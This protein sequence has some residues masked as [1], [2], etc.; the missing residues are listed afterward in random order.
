[1]PTLTNN[2]ER[3][4]VIE[5][6]QG[7]Y[8]CFPDVCVAPNGDL[9]AV[10]NE[11]D[12]HVSTRSRLL[13]KRSADKG[14]TWSDPAYL[15]SDVSHCPRLTLLSGG[16]LAMLDDAG[17]QV[18]WSMDSGLSWSQHGMVG[19]THGLLDRIIELDHET[20][21]TTGHSHRGTYPHPKTRQPTTE[22]M[23]YISENRG[24]K[25]RPYSVM[26][27]DKWLV[28]CEASMTMLPDGSLLALLRENSMVY[29]PMYKSISRDSG[30]TW[31]PPAPTPLIGHRPT[32]ALTKSGKLLIT[33]RDVGPS[34]G[35]AAWLGDANELDE[36]EVH[37]LTPD[38]DV[39]ALTA[40]GLLIKSASG[41]DSL[42]RYALR[43]MTDPETAKAELETEVRVDEA[44]D[45]A[46]G[47]RLGAW[48]RIF[49]DRIEVELPDTKDEDQPE[50]VRI[51]PVRFNT[52]RVNYEKGRCT[53]TVNGE[54][55]ITVDADPM[56]ADTRA[57]LFGTI[58]PKKKNAGQSLWKNVRLSIDE[59]AYGRRYLWDWKHTMGMPDEYV[60]S[61]VLELKNDR[62]ASHPDFGYSG[63][64]EV[65]PGTFFCAFHHGDGQEPDYKPGFSSHVRG[66]TFYEDDFKS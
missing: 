37:S 48:W 50:P 24:R 3:H 62:F 47:I 65:E 8:T 42:A 31:S 49:P 29:E 2:S 33:Y 57:I 60:R 44:E 36:F 20:L 14:R 41:A 15:R 10:Y 46:C 53:L 45:T 38:P 56:Q 11:F 27:Y 1:M 16:Q 39:P 13:L 25:W 40:D 64:A 12:R 34:G 52:L 26:A 61:R 22:Q 55:R 19:A 23:V 66:A 18:F 43:P 59:P 9:L 21:L 32:M 7:H 4:V 58:S 28:L 54:E 6:R 30:R 35:T 63:W 5:K 17:H 51:E